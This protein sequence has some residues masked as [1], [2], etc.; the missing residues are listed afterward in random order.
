MAAER[1]EIAEET[2]PAWWP[3]IGVHLGLA[4]VA[5]GA[6]YT[7]QIMIRGMVPR[8]EWV[9]YV[10]VGVALLVTGAL[11]VAGFTSAAGRGLLALGATMLLYMAYEPQL[12]GLPGGERLLETPLVMF[13]LSLAHV[14]IIIAGLFLALQVAVDR[15]MLPARVPFRAPLF[16][17]M[18]LLLALMGIMWLALRDVYDLSMTT[19][20]SV[21]VLRTVAYGLLMLVCLT[22]PGVRGAGRTPH[23]YLG[24][25]LLG[26]VARNLLV[27]TQ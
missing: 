18:A 15:R 12:V 14:G 1:V 4:V 20:P 13:E 21:L 17:A 27:N 24:L 10:V 8:M 3:M 26:A 6:I 19:S 2:R 23:I 7:S 22:I 9:G 5:F 25:A 16:A 11:P